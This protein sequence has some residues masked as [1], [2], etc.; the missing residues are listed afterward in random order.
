VLDGRL[1]SAATA[2]TCV[3]AKQRLADELDV[4]AVDMESRAVGEV[5]AA[6]GLPFVVVRVIVDGGNDSLPAAAESFVDAA[7]DV[8]IFRALGSLMRSPQNIPAL[9]RLGRQSAVAH[10]CL[11]R[12]A[13]A[14][15]AAG[16][17]LC[18][19]APT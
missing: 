8:R 6:A 12:V 2:V 16:Y 18:T 13:T 14:L 3:P 4:A 10:A 1:A 17:G 15:A 5:A 19:E 11:A 7:G 9:W